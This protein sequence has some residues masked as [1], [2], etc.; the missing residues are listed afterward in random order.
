[1]PWLF[2]KEHFR[3]LGR[4]VTL[5]NDEGKKW[6]VSFGA[7]TRRGCKD[8]GKSLLT[9]T[10]NPGKSSSS[11]WWRAPTSA[12]HD[13][14]TSTAADLRL[15]DRHGLGAPSQPVAPA[16]KQIAE[17]P[18]TRRRLRKVGEIKSKAEAGSTSSPDSLISSP[19][20]P[21][22]IHM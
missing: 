12:S 11:S 19:E 20:W 9:T 13:H 1:V 16:D 5:E 21:H 4:V 22:F 10:S 17:A 14:S 8:G 18:F 15:V 6:R 7:A 3:K 2:V